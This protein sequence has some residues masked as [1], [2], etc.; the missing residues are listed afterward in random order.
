MHIVVVPG[1]NRTGSLSLILAKLAAA[2]YAELGHSVDL[3]ELNLGAEFLAPDVYAKPQPAVTAMVNR[4]L[5][6]DGVLFVV[7]EYNGSYPG[8]LKLFVDMLPYPQGFE[9]RPC[10][11]I[12]LAAGQF[13]SLRA[14]EHL[15]AVAGYRN[16]YIFPNRIFIGA[17]KT[18]FNDGMKLVDAKLQDRIKK[19]A[20]EFSHFVAMVKAGR[21]A[22]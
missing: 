18:Q 13:Q 16:A 14:V 21:P 17:S 22:S 1:T 5:A 2:D 8:I 6:A 20:G 9:K 4:F 3:L 15:Q 19:Q 7:P 10:A 12:G 11:F